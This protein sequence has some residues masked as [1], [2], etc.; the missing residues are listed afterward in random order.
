MPMDTLST[1]S[2]GTGWWTS[3]ITANHRKKSSKYSTT[4]SRCNP[5]ATWICNPVPLL[6]VLHEITNFSPFFEVR[7]IAQRISSSSIERRAPSYNTHRAHSPTNS[8]TH[9]SHKN[10]LLNFY[11]FLFFFSF[12][13]YIQFLFFQFYI[14]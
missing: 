12:Y 2:I 10:S 3:W 11:L 14:S 6:P 5:I 9:C 1:S 8:E 7:T 13:F 4:P